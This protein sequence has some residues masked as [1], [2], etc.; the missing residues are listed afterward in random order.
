MRAAGPG[1]RAAQRYIHFAVAVEVAP[2][3]RGRVP[4]PVE[5]LTA[6]YELKR[7]LGWGSADGCGGMQHARGSQHVHVAG[8]GAS[9]LDLGGDRGAQMLEAVETHEPG[10]GGGRVDEPQTGECLGDPVHHEAVLGAVLGRRKQ[11]GREALVGLGA[12]AAGSG[13]GQGG[14]VQPGAVESDQLLGRG[15]EEGGVPN[16][17]REGRAS[18][19]AASQPVQHGDDVQLAVE[20]EGAS[21]DHLVELASLDRV[22]SGSHKSQVLVVPVAGAV[23]IGHS[24]CDRVSGRDGGR[25]RPEGLQPP[26]ELGRGASLVTV[27]SD[28][29]GGQ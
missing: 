23:A 27:G 8:T 2:S 16:R 20:G 11:P 12:V 5:A 9:A 13:A 14:C 17:E 25:P 10:L 6:G 21:Q 26:F 4:P 18:R 24:G 1:Q 15:P 28:P 7:G 29:G 3:H 22:H 19:I